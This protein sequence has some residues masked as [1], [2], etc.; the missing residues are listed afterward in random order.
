MTDPSPP[1]P[2]HSADD[3]AWAVMSRL[4]ERPRWQRM[5]AWLVWPWRQPRVANDVY[6]INNRREEPK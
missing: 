4:V 3:P 6:W 2:K 1:W 5:L